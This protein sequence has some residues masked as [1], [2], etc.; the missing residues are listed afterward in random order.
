MWLEVCWSASLEGYTNKGY[1][2]VLL[3]IVH[4]ETIILL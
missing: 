4:I 3:Y 2:H 1:Y